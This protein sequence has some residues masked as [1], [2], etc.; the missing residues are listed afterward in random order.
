QAAAMIRQLRVSVLRCRAVRVDVIVRA[1]DVVAAAEGVLDTQL[2]V[3]AAAEELVREVRY[4][5][6]ERG[7]PRIAVIPRIDAAGDVTR[8]GVHLP[9]RNP[10]SAIPQITTLPVR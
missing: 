9:R 8:R 3:V 6:V 5:P 2:E 10:R 4:L 1:D 7:S